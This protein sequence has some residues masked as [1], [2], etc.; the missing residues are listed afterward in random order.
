MVRMSTPVIDIKNLPTL[1][2]IEQLIIA[3]RQEMA[4]L[5]KLKSLASLREK[6][7]PAAV[8]A[9][10]ERPPQEGEDRTEEVGN[11]PALAP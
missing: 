1:S 11:A 6:A 5:R 8:A 7:R 9:S 2:E 3:K 10:R 4:E